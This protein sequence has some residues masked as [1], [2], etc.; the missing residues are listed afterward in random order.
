MV[1]DVDVVVTIGGKRHTNEILEQALELNVPALPLAFAGGASRKFWTVYRDVVVGWFSLSPEDTKFL[2]ELTA[3]DVAASLPET[4]RRVADL[5]AR[6]RISRCLVLLP[7]D[8]VH[9]TLFRDFIKRAVESVM[10]CVRLDH[11]PGSAPIRTS[12]V[13]AVDRASVASV[14]RIAV[15]VRGREPGL[16]LLRAQ[17]E[18]LLQLRLDHRGPVAAAADGVMNATSVS[19]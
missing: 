18:A 11:L 15:R 14:A 17:P 8:D 10:I 6:A 5:I 13:D 4:A 2:D 3:T 1:H 16:P 12:F 19:W 9:N 7:Y